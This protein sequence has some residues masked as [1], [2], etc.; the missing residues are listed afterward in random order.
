MKIQLS[1]VLALIGLPLSALTLNEMVN[2]ITSYSIHYTKLYE[3]NANISK[4]EEMAQTMIKEGYAKNVDLLEV[5]AKRSNIERS[6]N[7][8]EA[9]EQLLYHYLS[10]LLNQNV[11]RNN[12]V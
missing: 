4:L 2:V 9:N 8:M 3:I 10:F 1:V 6:I 11:S 7:Q 12:F 5:Q